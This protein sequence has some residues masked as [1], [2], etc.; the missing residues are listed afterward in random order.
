ML[1]IW[2]AGGDAELHAWPGGCHVFESFAPGTPL[3]RRAVQARSQWSER[4]LTP[5]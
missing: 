1:R 3:A 4:V 2:R 5:G